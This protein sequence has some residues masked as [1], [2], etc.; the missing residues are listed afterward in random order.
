VHTLTISMRNGI[1]NP[2]PT[3]RPT[4]VVG[5]RPEEEFAPVGEET[6]DDVDV[7]LDVGLEELGDDDDDEEEELRAEFALITNPR[8]VKVLL[9]QSLLFPILRDGSWRYRTKVESTSIEF[10]STPSFTPIVQS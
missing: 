1:P 8:L 6:D 9:R 3:P 4:L 5:S 2:R 7:L 10:A